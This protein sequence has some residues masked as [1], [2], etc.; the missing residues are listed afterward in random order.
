MAS[1]P[2]PSCHLKSKSSITFIYAKS[3]I[4]RKSSLLVASRYTVKSAQKDIL[5]TLP[6]KLPNCFKMWI[7]TSRLKFYIH[8]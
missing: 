2:Q 8:I 1:L 5:K 6:Q 3:T 4:K 7:M